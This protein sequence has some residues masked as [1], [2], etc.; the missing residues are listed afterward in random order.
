MPSVWSKKG[1]HI[2]DKLRAFGNKEKQARYACVNKTNL[3][4][5]CAV[6]KFFRLM[7]IEKEGH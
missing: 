6:L 2:L 5:E 3:K 4:S 7:R 1:F